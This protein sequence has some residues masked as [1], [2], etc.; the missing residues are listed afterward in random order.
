MAKFK[1]ASTKCLY[2]LLVQFHLPYYFFKQNID[3]A[4]CFIYLVPLGDRR[5]GPGGSIKCLFGGKL[6]AVFIQIFIQSSVI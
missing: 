5:L 2:I 1:T 4:A 6:V 3:T